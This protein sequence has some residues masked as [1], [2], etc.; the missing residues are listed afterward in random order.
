MLIVP[1][2][3]RCACVKPKRSGGKF[4]LAYSKLGYHVFTMMRA[5]SRTISTG[6]ARMMSQ[7]MMRTRALF[8]ESS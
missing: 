7:R 4:D 1:N 8:N 6:M 3:R 2:S 5:D